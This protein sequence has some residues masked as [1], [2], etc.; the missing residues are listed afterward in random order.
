MCMKYSRISAPDL[1]AELLREIVGGRFADERLAAAG[2]AVE[3]ETFRRGVLELLE[4]IRV[5]Q[6]QLDRV[7]DRLERLLLA[8]DF[9]PRQLGHVV[10]VMIVAIAGCASTSSATR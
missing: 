7:A 10:E 2:R 1:A 3:E 5:Q 8:A 9:F 4:Q 6:R